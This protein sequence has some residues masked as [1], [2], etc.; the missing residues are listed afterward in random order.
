MLR[1]QVS[2]AGKRLLSSNS[3]PVKKSRP[4]RNFFLKVAFAT[5]VFYAGGV[6]LS[7]YNYQFAELFTDN[8]PFAEE[9]V[10][11]VE[12]VNDGTLRTPHLS[13][14]EIRSKFGSLS[15]KVESIPN[16][17][18][19]SSKITEG[20]SVGASSAGLE[21]AS[22]EKLPLMTLNLPL[23]SVESDNVLVKSSI[24][25]FNE[26]IESLNNQGLQLP[27][28]SIQLLQESYAVLGS[29]M[30]QLSENFSANIDRALKKLSKELEKAVESEKRQ[31]LEAAKLQLLQ[32]FEKDLNNAKVEFEQKFDSQLQY[33][34][35]A[36]EQALLAKHKNE[37]A[38]LSIK[39]VQE[40]NK[41]ISDKVEN[42]R[43]GKLKNLEDLNESV[44]KISESLS[45]VES[46]LMKAECINQ[47]TRLVSSI[48]FKLNLDQ[49]P[50]VD[51]KKDLNRLQT[52]VEILPGKPNKCSSNGPQL[53]D[54]VLSELTTLLS[55]QNSQI[56]SNEQLYN[57]WFLLQDKIRET[58]LLP[59]NAGFLGHISAKFFSSL[60]FSKS[61][62]SPEN[63][64]DSII[65][66]VSENIRINKLDKAV[67]EVV[68]L[69]GW[70]RL[71]ADD[72]LKAARAKLEFA[73]L[74][75][76][77]DHEIKTL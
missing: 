30:K 37:L 45:K 8:V 35:K 9:L 62:V 74:I 73:T 15:R 54:V 58:S 38:M 76:V 67:E 41:I 72:W 53:I 71:E 12:S 22:Q 48:K 4:V 77:V 7:N 29:Q 44:G 40:F 6:A 70:S 61:G 32:Q 57:R 69:Q 43:N 59:P 27:E 65:A 34:L 24:D 18:S 49:T 26:Q 11:F 47:L 3:A 39:Q 5:T 17:G 10:Q 1:S 19:I 68:Q 2:L 14:E 21:T 23:L 52:L 36:N 20:S 56:L 31:E 64:I 25:A 33:S 42:E 60:L 63:D 50:S 16:I 66:R 75:D 28:K 51:L 13:L 55:K 46:T